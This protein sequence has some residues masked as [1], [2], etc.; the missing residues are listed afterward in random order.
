MTS[1]NS[2]SD[3]GDY[4]AVDRRR[5]M[6]LILYSGTATAIFQA[7]TT[8]AVFTSFLATYLK[9]D[10]F[11]FGIIV[12]MA[13]AAVFAQFFGSLSAE[14][15]GTIKPKYTIYCLPQRLLWIIL[16]LGLAFI[17]HIPYNLRMWLIAGLFFIT[18]FFQ[19][20]GAG[21]TLSW[22]SRLVPM[23]ISGRFFGMRQR[24][25]MI[26]TL[27]VASG[28]A[29]LIDHFRGNGLIYIIIFCA[30]AIFGVVDILLV[31]KIPEIP[32]VVEDTQIT[33]KEIISTPWQFPIFRLYA[34]FSF[35]SGIAAGM[36]EPFIWKYS[37]AP[38]GRYGLGM[39][40]FTAQLLLSIIPMIIMA[41]FAPHWG[42][43]L[44]RLGPRPVLIISAAA[45]LII[46]AVW[47]MMN[48]SIFWLIP[49]Q[50]IFSGIALSGLAQVD[51]FMR[52]KGFPGF[53]TT[54]FLASLNVVNG[55]S[56]MT[57][58]VLG[59]IMASF[60]MTNINTIQ[61]LPVWV[62]NY[63]P[64]FFIALLLR[65][66]LFCFITLRL[67]L[68]GKKDGSNAITLLGQSLV[69]DFKWQLRQ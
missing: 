63:H 48:G 28:M 55:I 57:G 31:R 14:R 25:M 50:T 32:R 5:G 29:L 39:P 69:S 49:I 54:S 15:S 35:V 65:A 52:V 10:D 12:A 58:S 2:N 60:W 36:M 61:W 21:G 7:L 22:F 47:L 13:P 68:P 3:N 62:S 67:P 24:I 38:A 11:W 45:Q 4:T 64:L 1:I 66:A 37:L 20:F 6:G 27:I 9:V 59:G 46:S 43:V 53:R 26:A 23:Q 41:W 40:V 56:A 17:I 8:G 18:A 34:L 33:L 51:I 30:A 42:K 16:S 44:D 19:H